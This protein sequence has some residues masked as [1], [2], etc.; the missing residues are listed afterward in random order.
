MRDK[1]GQGRIRQ[2]AL[3]ICLHRFV[4]PVAVADVEPGHAHAQTRYLRWRVVNASS[5]GHRGLGIEVRIAASEFEDLDASGAEPKQS[6]HEDRGVVYLA[7]RGR[8]E[9]G[10]DRGAEAQV[11]RRLP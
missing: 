3:E 2:R 8:S 11:G 5:P 7:Q 1:A 9:R 4:D 10:A 6:W